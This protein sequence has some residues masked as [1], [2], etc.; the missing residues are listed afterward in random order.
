MNFATLDDVKNTNDPVINTEDYDEVLTMILNGLGE[1]F[2]KQ[3]NRLFVANTYT[4]LFKG[5]GEYLW[6]RENPIR[7]I[8]NIWVDEDAE[9]GDSSIINPA[10]YL[11]MD[12]GKIW[13]L[14]FTVRPLYYS[15]PTIKVEYE[16]GYDPLEVIDG[17]YSIPADLKLAFVRQAQYDLKR[18]KDM[19]IATVTF[20][21][22]NVIKQPLVEM[23][24]QVETVIQR[25][26][27][28]NI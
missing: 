24:P 25:Y 16:G 8:N 1:T 6:L 28:P 12:E 19:G 3:C 17:D 22:G 10:D 18:R 20:K 13:S 2:S 27:V 21:D 15:S 11:L 9:W 14:Y 26:R 7:Q 5:G 23:L 4:E